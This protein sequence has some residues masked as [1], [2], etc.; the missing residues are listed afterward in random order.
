MHVQ[1]AKV[2]VEAVTQRRNKGHSPY[3]TG[4][5]AAQKKGKGIASFTD[6]RPEAAKQLA[7]QQMVN[8][9]VQQQHAAQQQKGIQKGVA[10]QKSDNVA[11]LAT[12]IRYGDFQ[13]FGYGPFAMGAYANTMWVGTE[14]RARL[15]RTDPRRGSATSAVG[16]LAPAMDALN[17]PATGTF[18]LRF[19]R[20]GH[21]LNANAGGLAV[22]SNL[23]PI[24]AEANT[25][26]LDLVER[27]MKTQLHNAN[28]VARGG[29]AGDPGYDVEYR[30]VAN[31]VN[32]G[33]NPYGANHPD[34]DLETHWRY[35]RAGQDAWSA[36]R[37]DTI[38]SRSG[39]PAYANDANWASG[40]SRL[41]AVGGVHRVVVPV[42]HAAIV[43]WGGAVPMNMTH[44][45][46]D[47]I[48][49]GALGAAI[50]NV[51]TIHSWHE[52]QPTP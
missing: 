21:L 6:N 4:K 49:G 46:I 35:W 45:I 19:W 24:T 30:A 14:V 22:D 48:Y 36:W 12:D 29:D 40:G 37:V 7:I 42:G 13:G 1:H 28:T 2:P 10:Q 44:A 41:T 31:P 16:V 50:V 51:N 11:Q 43:A 33:G 18:P 47:P 5:A 3:Q 20:Q 34:V 8:N 9:S 38:K 52:N 32:L 39:G 23:V 15:D 25:R 27:G 26:H 17:N